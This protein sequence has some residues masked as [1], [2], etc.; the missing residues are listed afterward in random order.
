[1][2]EVIMVCGTMSNVGKSVLVAALCR[3]LTREGYLCA[4]FKSQNM[5]LNS[6]VTEEGLEMGRAQVMQA[7]AAR[8]KPVAAMNPILLKPTGRA[9]SQVILNGKVLGNMPAAEYFKFRGSLMPEIKRAY[10]TLEQDSDI[11]VIEGAGSPAEINLKQDDIVNMGL[12]EAVDAPVILV[13]DID[14]GG[15]F[16]QLYGT[17]ALLE[18]SERAR[19]KGLVIN[20]FR[21]DV[22]LLAPGLRMLEER[23]GVPVLGVIP[24]GDFAL[25][26]EDSLAERL[27]GSSRR[28]GDDVDI[29]VIRLPHISNF[30]DFNPLELVAGTRLRYVAA[31]GELGEPDLVILPGTKNTLGDLRWLKQSGMAERI[32]KLAGR[33]L[34]ILGIC[35][36]FQ[37]LGEWVADP[38]GVEDEAGGRQESGLSLLPVRTVLEKEKVTR[39]F[40][41][42]LPNLS[43]IFSAWKKLSVSG[44]EIHAG[45]TEDLHAESVLGMGVGNVYG[46]YVHGLFEAGGAAVHLKEA[47]AERRRE[48]RVAEADPGRM[49]AVADEAPGVDPWRNEEVMEVERRQDEAV[50]DFAQFKDREY[51]R[52][53][54]LVQA[55]LD[56]EAIHRILRREA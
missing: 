19:V 10:H 3:I 55:H 25:E 27:N 41:G 18:E 29:V 52:L 53:A 39:Q 5:A 50:I 44:Y 36:G 15:V 7:E 43:G 14:R 51:D 45:R 4:P 42:V 46:T 6:Y 24:Y 54:D 22:S 20:K 47:L 13:G 34:P 33:Q 37:M 23:C 30:T 40:A 9:I 31:A 17:L 26:D 48:E 21:G 28:R 56:M 32:R 49:E 8:R 1:M 16:A 38:W 11:I 12:A 2:A 35:G